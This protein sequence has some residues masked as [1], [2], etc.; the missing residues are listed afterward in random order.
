MLTQQSH[1]RMECLSM[2]RLDKMQEELQVP[3][4]D[5]SLLKRLQ[6]TQQDESQATSG[7]NAKF[8]T[9]IVH[10]APRIPLDARPLP[11]EHRAQHRPARTPRRLHRRPPP[12]AG[13]GLAQQALAHVGA[14]LARQDP[15]HVRQ[16]FDRHAGAAAAAGGRP[17]IVRGRLRAALE[18]LGV[19]VLDDTVDEIF[20]TMDTD[21]DDAVDSDEF[22]AAVARPSRVEQWTGGIAVDRLLAS[23]LSPV[24]LARAGAGAGAGA[25][26]GGDVLRALSRCSDSGIPRG[27]CQG[28]AASP[29]AASAARVTA[30]R[31]LSVSPRRAPPADRARAAS[32]RC[33]PA[34][35]GAGEGGRRGAARGP[36]SGGIRLRDPPGSPCDSCDGAP[37][38]AQP[39]AAVPAQP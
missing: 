37:A 15:E 28:H 9:V 7:A 13:T 34:R 26:A 31:A 8:R 27:T 11:S 24:V 4:A 23:A 38:P 33:R 20:A 36:R 18:E 32:R 10:R 22:A 5:D 35:R 17:A 1:D 30:S 39:G 29:V 2:P 21:G 12:A 6:P 25:A 14:F 3:N 16:I 19:L